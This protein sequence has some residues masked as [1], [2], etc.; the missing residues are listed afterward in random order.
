MFE[1]LWRVFAPRVLVASVLPVRLLEK[2]GSSG[3]YTSARVRREVKDL[4][5]TGALARMA[6]AVACSSA[7]FLEAQPNRT[8]D[9]YTRLR[10]ELMTSE[11]SPTSSHGGHRRHLAAAVEPAGG[12][13]PW[14]SAKGRRT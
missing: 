2:H 13:P 1:S 9:D 10:A 6:F 3:F 4:K 7:E 11:G 12:T 8:L 5:L 14:R